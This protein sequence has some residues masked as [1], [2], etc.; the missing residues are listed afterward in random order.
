[1]KLVQ[2]RDYQPQASNYILA[3]VHHTPAK[4]V[5]ES[6]IQNVIRQYHDM[7]W[8]VIERKNSIHTFDDGFTVLKFREK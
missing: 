7:N 5:D 4:P 6:E 3:V 2:I 1:M 8:E